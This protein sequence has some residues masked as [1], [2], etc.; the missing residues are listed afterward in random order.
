[1]ANNIVRIRLDLKGVEAK[2]FKRVKKH[3][4][5]K[6]NAEVVRILLSNEFVFGKVALNNRR[7][8]RQP[9]A[10]EVPTV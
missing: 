4:G 9:V 5:V 7:K 6:A 10:T 3:Y 2:E 1:M 8:Q